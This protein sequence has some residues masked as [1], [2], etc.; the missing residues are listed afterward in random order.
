MV[1]FYLV[2][3]SDN[4]ITKFYA[5]GHSGYSEIGSDIVCAAISALSQNTVYGIVEYLKMMFYVLYLF[6][7]ETKIVINS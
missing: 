5:E 6:I 4:K 3:N 2:R 7:L 1:K